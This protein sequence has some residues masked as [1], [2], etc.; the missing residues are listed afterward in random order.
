MALGINILEALSAETRMLLA[1]RIQPTWDQAKSV[2]YCS[3]SQS[4]LAAGIMVLTPSP[5]AW[6]P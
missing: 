5:T 6:G 3:P 4:L 1:F 2:L